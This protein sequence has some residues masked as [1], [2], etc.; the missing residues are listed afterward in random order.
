MQRLFS[1]LEDSSVLSAPFLRGLQASFYM[2][3]SECDTMH[4]Y[5]QLKAQE[6][7]A[8]DE[9]GRKQGGAGTGACNTLDR[10]CYSS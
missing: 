10:Q 6:D 3:Q 1:A 7:E 2:P 8:K 5:L 9:E 4:R